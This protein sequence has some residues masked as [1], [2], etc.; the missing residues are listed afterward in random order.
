M[1][2]TIQ[3]K[4][5]PDSTKSHFKVDEEW[6]TGETGRPKD[7]QAARRVQ[8]LAKTYQT[9]RPESKKYSSRAQKNEKDLPP[10]YG[11]SVHIYQ[12]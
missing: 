9:G 3:L 11:G 12:K 1:Y 4:S 5:D 7:A 2:K 8:Q 10:L 6:K